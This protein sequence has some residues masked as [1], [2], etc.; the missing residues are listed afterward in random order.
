[1]K[2]SDTNIE[3]IYGFPWLVLFKDKLSQSLTF[4]S[5]IIFPMLTN[6]FIVLKFV[7]STSIFYI[8]LSIL[9]SLSAIALGIGLVFNFNEIKNLYVN[10][11]NPINKNE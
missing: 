5:I 1:M 7:K 2:S 9:L 6:I 3:E 10:A 4:I 8:G 11:K